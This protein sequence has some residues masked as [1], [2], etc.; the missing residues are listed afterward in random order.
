MDLIDKLAARQ[1]AVGVVG[2]GYVG[3]PL[4]VEFADAGF[5]VI[6]VDVSREKV[7]QI[8]LGRNYISDIEGER[9]AQAVDSGKLRAT[10][11]YDVIRALDAVSIC[12][13]T[14]LSKS[15][16]PDITHILRACNEISQ[17][18]H[19]PMLIV[20]ESTS[21]PGTTQEL[22]LPILEKSGLKVGSDFF[23]AFSPE[24]V[25]PGNSD[26]N[27][28]NT[29]KIISGISP[30][31]VETA[32]ALYSQVVDEL[33]PVSSAT[34]AEMVKLL[35]NTFRAINIGAINEMAIIC[36]Q[37]GVNV[38]EI[39]E[40]ARS[41]PFGF[42]P[43]YPGP[44]LGGHCIPID[45]LYL[46]WKMR[47]LNYRT[48]FIELADQVNSAM[49]R[50]VVDRIVELLNQRKIPINGARILI[51]GVTYKRDIDDTRESP[52]LPIIE[53]LLELEGNISYNDPY[54]PELEYNG[55]K[56]TGVELSPELLSEQDLVVV[57]TDHQCYDWDFVVEHSRLILDT[58]NGV[59]DAANPSKVVRL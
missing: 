26:F 29:P 50:Y 54:V 21:Y 39:I 56:L 52:A 12:V 4:A 18:M 44:G 37:L 10:T 31:C 43:F 7:D 1:A 49:P 41:K 6:G 33:V 42:M 20:L 16:E 3:L 38:W 22:V 15:R 40:A 14:P 8:N 27:T 51:L 17:R 32:S 58:R 34:A 25:D 46:S 23:L 53:Q 47:K 36:H 28:R 13:P 9:L 19:R 45:P 59:G 24:R 2:L 11:D 5:E 35:E 48:R 30:R 55:I 57:T